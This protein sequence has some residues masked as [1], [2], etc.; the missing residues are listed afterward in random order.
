VSVRIGLCSQMYTSNNLQ[1][2]RAKLFDQTTF[3]NGFAPS[4]RITRAAALVIIQKLRSF[5]PNIARHIWVVRALPAAQRHSFHSYLFSPPTFI[6]NARAVVNLQHPT[7]SEYPGL[8]IRRFIHPHSLHF[9]SNSS[10]SNVQLSTK[11]TS[12]NRTA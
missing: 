9:L 3:T 5:L 6:N 8:I 10:S 1:T 12:E 7:R 11:P 2:S 4:S